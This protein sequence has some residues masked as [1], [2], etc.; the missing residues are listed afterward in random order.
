MT[1]A[2]VSSAIV[3]EQCRKGESLRLMAWNCCGGLHRK[4]EP[5]RDAAPDIVVLSEAPENS[6]ELIGGDASGV[7]AGRLPSHG[8][9]VI[10]LNG[11]QIERLSIEIEEKLFVA[12]R[13]VRGEEEL[14][15]IG[16]CVK[17]DGDYVSPTLR[18]LSKLSDL[19]V[20]NNAIVAGDFN[21]SATFDAKRNPAGR[22]AHVV[23]LASELDLVSAW[24]DFHN[25]SFGKEKSYTYFHQW[26]REQPFHIDYVFVPRRTDISSVELGTYD[27]FV[28][29][30]LS[31]HVP[32][33]ID[34]QVPSQDPSRQSK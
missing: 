33:L 32:L 25:E 26:K 30:G 5:I 19:I 15:V 24:H 31:D 9:A 20:G 27:Q 16:V 29:T 11:W 1:T 6:A 14:C 13:A 23:E 28:A 2:V 34:I 4:T 3:H 18:A 12:A 7:W 10:G 8:L 17:R 21:Q 22:F